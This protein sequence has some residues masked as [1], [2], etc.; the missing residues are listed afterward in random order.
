MNEWFGKMVDD[1]M[2]KVLFNVRFIFGL[3]VVSMAHVYVEVVYVMD[4]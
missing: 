1:W 3:T 4:E 2:A